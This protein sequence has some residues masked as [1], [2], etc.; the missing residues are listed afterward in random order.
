MTIQFRDRNGKLQ[1]KKSVLYMRDW[2]L[3]RGMSQEDMADLL[4]TDR[5]CISKIENGHRVRS[6]VDGE[7]Y[8][9]LYA[10]ALEIEISDLYRNPQQG[11]KK[12]RK[13]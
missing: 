2:R 12:R 4:G 10:R 7:N 8:I 1:T 13:K 9:E 3:V 5:T 6:N 11:R